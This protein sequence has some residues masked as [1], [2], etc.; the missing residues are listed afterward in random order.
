MFSKT[1]LGFS[2]LEQSE[3]AN[4][5]LGIIPTSLMPMTEEQ[6]IGARGS[7]LIR[8]VHKCKGYFLN[9]EADDSFDDSEPDMALDLKRHK[10]M[11]QEEI[12]NVLE[13]C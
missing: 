13:H 1:N 2:P 8:G 6:L 10:L 12:E 4:Q 9:G 11:T 3:P 7:L 5:T